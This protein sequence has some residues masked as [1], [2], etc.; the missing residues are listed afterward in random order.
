MS[1]YGWYGFARGGEAIFAAYI[2]K[3]AKFVVHLLDNGHDVRLLT[4]EL[5]EKTAVDALVEEVGRARP[6][7]PSSRMIAEPSYSLHELM[8]QISAVDIVVAT[9]FH[10]IVCALK[11]GRPT[12]SLGYSRKNDVLMEEMGLGAVCQHVDSSTLTASSISSP[13][14]KHR[15]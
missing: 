3:L 2:E 10:N 4:R 14:L 9:R 7:V 12:I 15:L 1:H 5:T 8:L 13:R 6:D 11:L